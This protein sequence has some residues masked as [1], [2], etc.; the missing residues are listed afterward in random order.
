MQ[1]KRCGIRFIY[2]MDAHTCDSEGHTM[3]YVELEQ[4]LDDT[5]LFTDVELALIILTCDKATM[6]NAIIACGVIGIKLTGNDI[7]MMFGEVG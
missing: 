7:D 5:C 1:C 3:T 6:I 4:R 2:D